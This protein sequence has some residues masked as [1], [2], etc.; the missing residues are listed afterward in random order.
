MSKEITADWNKIPYITKVFTLIAMASALI[1]ILS[2]II[3]IW[4]EAFPGSKLFLTGL[5]LFVVSVYLV[6]TDTLDEDGNIKEK[7]RKNELG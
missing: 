5:L 4:W 2:I 6:R 7:Y 3:G 1:M